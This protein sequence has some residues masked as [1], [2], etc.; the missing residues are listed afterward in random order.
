[1]QKKHMKSE[2]KISK[3]MKLNKISQKKK[4]SWMIQRSISSNPLL[5]TKA[6][7]GVPVPADFGQ[8]AE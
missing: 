6:A 7:A 4:N 3:W 1:M 5:L 2:D 8:W